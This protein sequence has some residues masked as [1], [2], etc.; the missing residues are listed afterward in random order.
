MIPTSLKLHNF[1]SYGEN[2]KPL[3]FSIIELACLAGENGV[4][5]SSIFEAIAWALW[6][7]SRAK[8]D[9]DLIKHGQQEMWVDLEFEIEKDYFRILRKRSKKGRGQS[10]LFFMKRQ[11]HQDRAPEWISI[12]GSTKAETQE[13]IIKALRMTYETFV[14][15]AF[16]RQ[17]RADEFTIKSPVER[18]K[19][20]SEILNLY[21]YDQISEKAKE[22]SRNL[23]IDKE[24]T[25]KQLEYLENEIK[26]KNILDADAK[27]IK[28]KLDRLSQ[29]IN[30]HENEVK[31]LQQE[32][33][34]HDRLENEASSLDEKIAVF[35]KELGKIT[36]EISERRDKNNIDK[37]ILDKQ[38]DINEKFIELK[39]LQ[40]ENENLNKLLNKRI[41][42]IER[43]SE[44]E[45]NIYSQKLKKQNEKN[46]VEA[47]IKT[48]CEGMENKKKFEDELKIIEQKIGMV[49]KAEKE[50]KKIEN[51]LQRLKEGLTDN[52]YSLKHIE[53]LIE[54]INTSTK[55]LNSASGH[56]CPLC[57]Q[58]LTDEHKINVLNDY[59]NRK[60]MRVKEG[61]DI[62]LEISKF[63][64]KISGMLKKL[65]TTRKVI[66]NKS[67]YEA[68][69][70]N[71]IRNIQEINKSLTKKEYLIKQFKDIKDKL[72]TGTFA[73]ID[74]KELESI[75]DKLEKSDYNEIKHKGIRD[76]IDKL[77]KY[78]GM[79]LKLDNVRQKIKQE[80]EYI[81][82]LA[83]DA[84]EKEKT[85]KIYKKEREK[86]VLDD[87]LREELNNKIEIK[88]GALQKYREEINSIQ[89]NFGAISEKI[90][91]VKNLE[92]EL[93]E[94]KENLKKYI[95]EKS[96]Y[97]ELAR[98][99]GKNGI[100]AMIIEA[101]IPEIEDDA[102]KYLSKMTNGRM[103]LKFIT[104]REKKTDGD[105]IDTLDIL[106]EDGEGIRNYEMFSGGEAY[107]INFS[108]RMALSKLL[109]NR[110]GTK[111]QFLVIDEGFGTQDEIGRDNLIEAINSISA[112]FK[113]IL[114]ITHIQELKNAFPIRIEVTKNENGSNY[115]VMG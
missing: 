40:K 22:N 90:E 95:R 21:Y 26:D 64:S 38:K 50:N 56:K 10:Q 31:N 12:S 59:K 45:K 96:I 113:K 29:N 39:R 48:I 55:K 112:D 19:I 87:K 71:I 36:Q 16:L 108:I 43:K 1:M 11:N 60:N 42:L 92:K 32:K 24:S 7:K 73:Y 110:S 17:G 82:K 84:L 2:I 76:K 93:R 115:N 79:K 65:E 109:A 54:D 37:K 88:S 44:I 91:R 63:N 53:I 9:D 81:K 74:Y 51:Y 35:L 20:L 66:G 107:R 3:D 98:A 15:S 62:K 30:I 77:A 18:K 99:F 61:R 67:I 14:N 111:L 68:E 97:D 58:G 5:K 100:Q 75:N 28:R 72:N 6:G 4:G 69:K 41:I 106:I 103:R 89:G 114:V 104:Q 80:E 85:I 78:E 34:N 94:R 70:I 46:E 13:E 83:A 27:A 102:N 101:V 57:K 49:N 105:L 8:S 86:I 47:R 52:K 33:E 25:S 23:A